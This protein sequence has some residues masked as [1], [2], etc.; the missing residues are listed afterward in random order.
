MKLRLKNK[1]KNDFQIRFVKIGGFSSNL[2]NGY[3]DSFFKMYFLFHILI[4]KTYEIQGLI[5]ASAKTGI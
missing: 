3:V 4:F 2:Q 5:S 1:I